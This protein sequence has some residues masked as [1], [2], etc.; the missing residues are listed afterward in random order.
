MAKRQINRQ[1]TAS[2][3]YLVK[4]VKN[5]DTEGEPTEL[6]FTSAEFSRILN[7]IKDVSLLDVKDENIIANIK[8]GHEL[9]FTYHEIVDNHLHFGE[10]EGAYYGQEYRNN[11]LGVIAADSLNLR[12]FNYLTTRLSDGRILIGVTYNG[13]FGDYEGIRQCFTHLLQ[14]N[15]T[16]TSKTIKSVSDEIGAGVPVEVKLTFRTASARPERRGLFARSGVIAIRSTEY[17]DGFGE[18]VARMA[19]SAKGGIKD[20]KRSIADLVKASSM[21]E[22][23]DDDIVAV[24]ALVREQGRTRTIYFLGENNFSTKYP[25]KVSVS[26]NGTA[27]RTEVRSEL[28]NLMRSKIIPMISG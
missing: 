17:G 18:E 3:H 27:N 28:I 20:R 1:I 7:R 9:P 11:R 21:I 15:G 24:T 2:F 13:Q 22:L 23:E 25:L 5:E 10:F 19:R 26:A 16:V 4:T 14:S 6:P 8:L 12:R